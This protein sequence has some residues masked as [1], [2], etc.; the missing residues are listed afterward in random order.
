MYTFNNN[1]VFDDREWFSSE[2]IKTDCREW[3][4]TSVEGKG[5][6]P[7]FGKGPFTDRGPR[8]GSFINHACVLKHYEHATRK[9]YDLSCSVSTSV[10]IWVTFLH[11]SPFTRFN[12]KP[13]YVKMSCI[14]KTQNFS[15]SFHQQSICCVNDVKYFDGGPRGMPF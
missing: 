12:T 15:S 9:E 10:Y 14:V 1:H 5:G 2:F 8:F 13:T 11:K 7:L 4:S 6:V 3:L